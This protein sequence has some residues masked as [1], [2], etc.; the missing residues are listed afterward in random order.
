ML[1]HVFGRKLNRSANERKRLFRNLARSLIL[2]GQITTSFAKAKA[3]QPL[4]EKMVTRAK[5][6]NLHNRRLLL[7]EIKDRSVVDKLLSEVGPLFK[8]RP[9]GYTRIIKIG[10]RL[11]DN[12]IQV[13]I[14]FTQNIQKSETVK[15]E[16]KKET[17]PKAKKELKEKEIN[18]K[19]KTNKK[20]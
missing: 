12:T 3:V 6:N 4:V 10:N 2:N 7:K 18:A 5:V 15:K 8:S 1:H 13:M 20:K 11:G 16:V 17:A 9:G 19:D 14:S